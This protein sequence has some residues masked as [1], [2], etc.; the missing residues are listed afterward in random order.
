MLRIR[1]I[2]V[3]EEISWPEGGGGILATHLIL[4]MLSQVRELNVT[5]VSGTREPAT[6]GGIRC[7]F[8][9][10]L[11]TQNK[12]TLWMNLWILCH[13]EW[14]L[15]LVASSDLIYVPRY[16]YPVI[17]LANRLGKRTVVHLHDYQLIAYSATLLKNCASREIPRAVQ[18]E[19]LN[20]RGASRALA[21]GCFASLNRLGRA[22]VSHA[23]NVI[24]VSKRQAEVI[25]GH[26]SE[27][28][29][30]IRV[31]YNPPPDIP[32]L[33][34]TPTSPRSVLY[35]GGDSYVKGFFTFLQ[36]SQ[37][38][39]RRGDG[40]R[41]LVA[42]QIRSFASEI[43]RKLNQASNN[44]YEVLGWIT[45]DKV[46]QLNRVSQSI[47]FPSVS[48]ESFGYAV[49]ESMLS[50]TI[51]ISSRIG[52]LPEI[53]K[54]TYAESTMFQPGNAEELEEEIERVNSLSNEEIV[55]IGAG[56]RS[57]VREK[58]DEDQ[59]RRQIIEVFK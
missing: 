55:E 47:L 4:K 43:I 6:I 3:I 36:A 2:L 46:L 51:P 5:L 1:N 28:R 45:H 41:F 54:G 15:Q 35:L 18:F 20:N 10:L 44:S 30:K 59:I 57:V 24:C 11:R 22:W 12:V 29:K 9:P 26:A 27:L 7:I 17:Q 53:L 58:F 14:F 33:E 50:G 34:K 23:D 39:L 37:A 40:V 31:I 16:C 32:P 19:I 38:T 52:A 56:L 13:Q 48:E 42:G 21:S 49:V 8:A 25:S